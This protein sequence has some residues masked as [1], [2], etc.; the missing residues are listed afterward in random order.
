[1]LLAKTLLEAG[2]NVKHCTHN[3]ET[4]LH[5]FGNRGADIINLLVAYGA[6]LNARN[7]H[8]NTPLHEA[9]SRRFSNA[10]AAL[11]RAGSDTALLNNSGMTAHM[12]AVNDHKNLFPKEK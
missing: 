7:V 3:C 6:D 9:A 4:P 1:M 12:L 10:I 8:G 5:M 11:L 2:A